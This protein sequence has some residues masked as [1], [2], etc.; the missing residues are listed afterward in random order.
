MGGE[1]PS[2]VPELRRPCRLEIGRAGFLLPAR[3]T[4]DTL[5]GTRREPGTL[6][7]RHFGR[8]TS[9]PRCQETRAQ[10]IPRPRGVV[11]PGRGR[12]DTR[13]PAFGVRVAGPFGAELQ[14]DGRIMFEKN[15]CYLVGI[16]GPREQRTFF[17]VRETQVGTTG[18]G[19]E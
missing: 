3:P 17:E 10:G 5:D 18:P 2:G 7:Q 15:L 14:D 19:E 9:K 6:L 1:E 16:F 12:G 4:T 11:G 13:A 8:L